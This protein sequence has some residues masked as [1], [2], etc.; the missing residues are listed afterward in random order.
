MGNANSVVVVGVRG[1]LGMDE[2]EWR[3]R[4]WGARGEDG[5][6][7]TESERARAP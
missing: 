4:V 5:V 2:M 7:A 6:S 1:V 3:D